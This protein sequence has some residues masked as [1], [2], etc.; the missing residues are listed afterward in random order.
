MTF[1]VDD[2]L[3]EAGTRGQS[4]VVFYSALKDSIFSVKTV[5]DEV[6]AAG[7]RWMCRSISSIASAPW[8]WPRARPPSA[9][10]ALTR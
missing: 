7:K 4:S 8:I 5:N 9:A 3:R 10:M 2:R 1:M 6:R